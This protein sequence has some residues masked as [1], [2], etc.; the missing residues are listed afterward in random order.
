MYRQPAP[1]PKNRLPLLDRVAVKTPCKASWNDM[2][3]D[4]RVRFCCSCSKNVYDLSAMTEDE[5]EAFLGLHLDDQD[6]CVKLYRRPDGRILTSDCPRGAGTRHVRRAAMAGAAAVCAVA[7]MAG[8]VADAQ[9]PRAHRLPRSTSRFEVPRQ[10]PDAPWRM[11]T[12]GRDE[13][14]SV[15]PAPWGREVAADG[16]TGDGDFTLSLV[17]LTMV[18]K[19]TPY[20]NDTTLPRIRIAGGMMVTDGLPPDVIKRIARQQFGRFRV[21][22]NAGLRKDPK[23]AGSVVVQFTIGRDGSVLSASDHGSSLPDAAVVHDVV[24]AFMTMAFPTPADG[25]VVVTFPID[26]TPSPSPPTPPPAPAR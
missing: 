16:E 15:E 4:D 18:P 14:A 1:P 21:A 11:G 23:L 17:G 5:A 26:F 6:A 9:L 2:E 22:Y 7:A 10:P 8:V 3:G 24:G 20:R 25:P 13:M 19:V 12:V